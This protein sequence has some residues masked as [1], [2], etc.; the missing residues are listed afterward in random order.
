[1][2]PGEGEE[3]EREAG[4][5]MKDIVP[6]FEPDV[7][8]WKDD[9]YQVALRKERRDMTPK[10]WWLDQLTDEEP[11]T[12]EVPIPEGWTEEDIYRFRLQFENRL[13][14]PCPLVI[15][16]AVA[17]P[18]AWTFTI[19]PIK[20][21]ID[22]YVGDGKGWVDPFAGKNSPAEW[23]NDHNPDMPTKFH[24]DA[25]DFCTWA[26]V[27]LEEAANSM[28]LKDAYEWL[29]DQTL[30]EQLPFPPFR[31]VLFDPPYSYRQITEHYKSL[32]LKAS[33]LDTSTRFY[34]R[35]MNAICDSVVPG[36]YA[37]SCG[38]NSNG[39][40]KNRGFEPVELLVVAHGNHHNDT[41]VLVER[42][43]AKRAD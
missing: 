10:T 24:F 37:I 11:E 19:K 3:L 36:G 32:G 2:G 18:S 33:Q 23:T 22:R 39:F 16:R 21:L 34:S 26:S 40:G 8:E 7:N 31:G 14:N 28:P 29:Q 12:I 20:A 4:D 25:E 13:A 1:M 43:V 41:L 9:P 38:W 30:P 42:K 6:Y 5:R 27:S 17:Q 15:T 35:V